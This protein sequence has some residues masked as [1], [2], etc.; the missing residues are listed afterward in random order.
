MR[1]IQLITGLFA[2]LYHELV[3]SWRSR[4]TTMHHWER[5]YGPPYSTDPLYVCIKCRHLT[6]CRQGSPSRTPGCF[7]S[8]ALEEAQRAREDEWHNWEG[9]ERVARGGS[10]YYKDKNGVRRAY[11]LYPPSSFWGW[12]SWR[13]KLL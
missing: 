8:A 11:P 7:G 6:T 9:K 2:V 10:Y 5:E 1:I 4:Q 3:W 13:I 12:V